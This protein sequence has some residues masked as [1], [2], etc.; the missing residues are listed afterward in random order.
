MD[1][2]VTK[3]QKLNQMAANLAKHNIVG[4]RDDAIQRAA[5][6]YGE[7]NNFSR[8]Q[9]PVY[10]TQNQDLSKD[11]RKLMFALQHLSNSFTELKH[12]HDKLEK[13][14]NDFI[15]G[16]RRWEAPKQDIRQNAFVEAPRQGVSQQQAQ[17][18]QR[19]QG[20]S[21]AQERLLAAMEPAKTRS[22]RDPNKAI[23]R[24]NVAPSEVSIDKFF[25]SGNRR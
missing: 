5:S 18:Q 2:D 12:S 7:E 21:D 15:V 3:M 11:V 19:M 13:D 23:D 9:Q 25:Y 24:N 20:T 10:E 16:Q 1:M 6:I 4:S 22:T 17:P 8:S 14:F